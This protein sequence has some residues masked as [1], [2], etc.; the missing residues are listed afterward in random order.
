MNALRGHT[1]A[2][3]SDAGVSPRGFQ[4]NPRRIH[5]KF[6]EHEVAL[7]LVL[8]LGIFRLSLSN[9]HSSIAPYL[10]LTSPPSCVTS[11]TSQ[12]IVT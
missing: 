3:V 7:Q 12:H 6:V 11:L 4:F 5:V 2:E 1:K 10:S 9:H 8:L